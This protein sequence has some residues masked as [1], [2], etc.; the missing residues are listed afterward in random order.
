MLQVS[1]GFLHSGR[2]FMDLK[3]R[4]SSLFTWAPDPQVGRKRVH[5]GLGSRKGQKAFCA[6]GAEA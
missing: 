6:H 1:G 4:T 3:A 5:V 2:W